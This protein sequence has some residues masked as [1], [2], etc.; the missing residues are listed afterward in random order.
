MLEKNI[1]FVRLVLYSIAIYLDVI[2]RA[3]KISIKQRFYSFRVTKPRPSRTSNEES[4]ERNIVIIGAS[5]AG[6]FAARI[7]A[8][9]LPPNSPFRVVVIEPHSHFNFTWVFPRFCV[10]KDHE[11][12][13]FI[14]YGKYIPPG[15]VRWVQGRVETVE[16]TL[17][18]LANGQR[19]P[20]EFLLV[21]T[22]SGAT[23]VLPSRTGVDEKIEG[24]LLLR[25]M[26]SMIER[27]Q[28]LVV[29]GG[30]AAGVEL[31]ADA[32]ALYQGKNVVLIHSHEAVMNRF[33]PELQVA[34]LKGLK[35]LGVQVI[36]GERLVNE[37]AEDNIATLS[38]GREVPCD[39]LVRRPLNIIAQVEL[40]YEYTDVVSRFI[41][42]DKNLRPTFCTHSLHPQ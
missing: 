30:G 21:A 17:V 23:D 41:V 6:Y 15:L 31:A 36:L 32:K 40:C 1:L 29:V 39:F 25:E 37:R 26:Q 28:N 2:S 14:P 9:S 38:S 27:S 7:I 33:G 12:K 10:T 13:A 11:H 4:K 18:Q 35:A 22:G 16:R 24:I 3:I 42:G 8:T 19:I 34:A 5:F 20:Y